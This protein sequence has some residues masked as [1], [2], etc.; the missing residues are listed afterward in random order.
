MSRLDRIAPPSRPR[1]HAGAAPVRR[2]A[3]FLAIPAVGALAP[4]V[5]LPTVTAH[6]RASGWAAVA[7]GQS[8]GMALSILVELGWALTGPQRVARLPIQQARM[9]FVVAQRTK[10][11][12]V[13]PVMI[14]GALLAALTAPTMPA[15]AALT[16]AA[17]TATGLTSVWYFIGRNR[18]AV[19]LITDTMPRLVAV[20]ITVLLI[21]TGVGLWCYPVIGM[22]LPSLLAPCTAALAAGARPGL[23][24]AFGLRTG[25][26]RRLLAVIFNQRAAVSGR[27]ISAAYIGMPVAL[28]GWFAPAA[29]AVFAAA[30]RLMRMGLNVL[31]AVPNSMQSWVGAAVDLDERIR[32][33]RRA[34]LINAALGALAGLSF[35]LL[36]PPVSGLIF[37]GVAT[38]PTSV[39]VVNAGVC[40]LVCTSRATGGIG[41]VVLGRVPVIAVS[42]AAGAVVGVPM[43]ILLGPT[44]GVLGG[45]CGELLAEAVVL[46][47]Q[48]TG[49]GVA[50]RR[51]ARPGADRIG[52]PR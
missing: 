32:R 24:R 1:V 13:L 41:L 44:Y 51:R 25:G 28:I 21:G 38:V 52:D 11:L 47:V 33:A 43:I 49:I 22:L 18:P 14:I 2:T 4:F 20:L 37:S 5:A 8:W 29:V 6:F 12:V 31:T 50:L 23:G 34:V 26:A 7:A 3:A 19:I 39:A 15:I 45:V 36:A 30:E 16:A 48:L 17:A 42:A 40:F 27:G 9:V 46:A 10:A 35:L